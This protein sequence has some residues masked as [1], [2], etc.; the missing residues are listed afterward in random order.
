MVDESFIHYLTFAL[1][2]IYMNS[3]RLRCFFFRCEYESKTPRR[4]LFLDE[5]MGGD[6]QVMKRMGND[7]SME[8]M[9]SLLQAL[10]TTIELEDTAPKLL[11][12]PATPAG[13]RFAIGYIGSS[14]TAIV[15]MLAFGQG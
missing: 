3:F 12:V 5:K 14:V 6:G 11:G 9:A 8:N 13:F 15:L 1:I 10:A 4:D 7:E 2:Y